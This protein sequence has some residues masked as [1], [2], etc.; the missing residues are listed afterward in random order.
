MGIHTLIVQ[1]LE[2]LRGRAVPYT[3][4]ANSLHLPE[5]L[6][7]ASLHNLEESGAVAIQE[8]KVQL[9][10]ERSDGNHNL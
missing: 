6:F 7:V 9:L 2:R 4:I 5:R 10:R 8:G 1:F 3:F